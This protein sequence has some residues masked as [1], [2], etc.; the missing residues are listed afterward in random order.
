MSYKLPNFLH[1]A[2]SSTYRKKQHTKTPWLMFLAALFFVP[3]AS[4]QAAPTIEHW[5]TQQGLGVYYVHVP[6]LPML[7]VRLVFSAG[8]TRDAEKAG[9]AMMTNAILPMGAAGLNADQLAEAFESVGAGVSNGAARDMA[10]LSLRTLTLPQE[11][12][13]AINTWLSVVTRPDFPEKDFARMK[14][15]TLVGLQAEKQSPSAIAN[16]AFFKHLYG[17]HPYA[18]PQNG[19]EA[20]V[21]ALTIADLK[22]FYQQYYVAK[23]GI[24]AIVGNIDRVAAEQLANRLSSRL[25]KG[26]KAAP[27]PKVKPLAAAK[28]IR[29]PFPSQQAHIMIGQTGNKRGDNDYFTLYLGNHIMGGGGFTSRLMKEVRDARGLSYSVYSYFSAMR[30]NGPF[31]L[32]L[33]TKLSQTD[34]AIKVAREVVTKFQKEGASSEE[35][36]AAKKDVNGGFPLNV[37]SNSDIVEYLAMIGFYN[38]PLDYLNTFTQNIDKITQTEILEAFKRRLSPEKMLTVIVGGE[39]VETANQSTP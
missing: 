24:L 23:N 13:K 35:L 1:P 17:D 6:Q 2:Y 5:Q 4:T 31:L 18:S 9:L 19:T 3:F 27:I 16:K 10:W 8:S 25:A 29:I 7:D 12:E 36:I 32:S 30:E 37:A 26:E 33:Q 11:Q 34:E 21:N 15:Q 20:S 14:K 22:A 39:K 38:L 28:T